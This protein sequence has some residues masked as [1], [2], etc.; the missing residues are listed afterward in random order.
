MLAVVDPQLPTSEFSS[1][2]KQELAKS[3]EPP[4][5]HE[6]PAGP[7]GFRQRGNHVEKQARVA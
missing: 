7:K 5:I 2:V 3:A 4:R 1:A 6:T